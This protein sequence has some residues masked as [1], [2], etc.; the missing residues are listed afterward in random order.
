MPT[1][2][3]LTYWDAGAE[4]MSREELGALQLERLRWQMERCFQSSELYRSK[5]RELGASP[6]DIT[7]L[8]AF[9][10]LPVVTKQELRDDQASHPPFGSFVVAPQSDWREIHPS[11]GTTGTPVNTIWSARDIDTITDFTARTMWQ[12]GVRPGD[13]VQNGFAYGLW[14]AGMS[15]HYA[16]LRLGCLV[17]PTGAAIAS[18]KQI[19]Y[20][21]RAGST[22]FLSTPSYA[23]HIAEGLRERGISPEDLPLRLGCFGGEAGAENAATRAKIER[24]LG[25]QAFDYYGL[26]EVGPTFASECQAKQGI[27]FAED[28]VLVECIDP[29]TRLPVQPGQ[30]GVLVFTHL[31]REA[32]PVLRYWS[33]DYARLSDDPCD[34]GRVH[35]RAIGGILGRQDD[36]IVF[37]GAK[38]YPSQVEKVVRGFP[39]LSDEFVV[40]VGREGAGA[41]IA[42]CTIVAEWAGG[43]VA[44]VTRRLAAALRGELGVTPAQRIEPYQTLQRTTFKA[45]RILEV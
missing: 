10:S 7:S 16:A 26:A 37:K 32:T 20:M 40:E 5:F 12:F 44:G 34:C 9:A 23:L 30:V 3:T 28:H 33:N 2:A 13:T 29:E 41:P 1:T 38:F 25:I 22:V 27:H 11:T 6:A 21:L 19:D 42:A 43:E 14:V 4:T 36:L 18:E 35:V 45:K 17:V 8:Q 15:S 39:E 31:T 24:G